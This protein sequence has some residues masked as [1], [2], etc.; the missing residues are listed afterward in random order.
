MNLIN[1]SLEIVYCS[2]LVSNYGLIRF[3]R[4]VSRFTDKPYN[5]FF[6]SS[7]FKS[8]CRCRIFF[9]ILNVATK[10]AVSA[11]FSLYAHCH[12]AS[13]C[14]LSEEIRDG[15]RSR[16]MVQYSCCLL[17]SQSQVCAMCCPIH[18]ATNQ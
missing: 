5:A 11:F 6:I 7:R 12:I 17:L 15:E 16:C 18:R 1:L 14:C 3:I 9:G 2:N 10:Q 13:P 4:F 8:P